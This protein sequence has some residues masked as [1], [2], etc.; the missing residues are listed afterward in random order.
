[1]KF[2]NVGTTFINP[3]DRRLDGSTTALWPYRVPTMPLRADR[4]NKAL[5]EGA[6]R[7]VPEWIRK[8]QSA[9]EMLGR[10]LNSASDNFSDLE[11]RNILDS[12]NTRKKFKS[13]EAQKRDLERS[14]RRERNKGGNNLQQ[15]PYELRALPV[16]RD[17]AVAKFA[18]SRGSR[19]RWLEEEVDQVD[20]MAHGVL[21]ES[22]AKKEN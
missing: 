6:D 12:Q 8:K 9:K 7:P 17:S 13:K 11:E 4:I 20:A 22:E 5:L 15:Y 3:L 10:G 19:K 16:S 14:Q 21:A 18:I 2:P 1:M